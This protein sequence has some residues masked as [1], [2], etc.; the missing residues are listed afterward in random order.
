MLRLEFSDEV[1][2]DDLERIERTLD[3]RLPRS[4]L[5]KWLASGIYEVRTA[6]LRLIDGRG[7][8]HRVLCG[9]VVWHDSHRNR[10][11]RHLAVA[12]QMHRGRIGRA[13]LEFAEG[14]GRPLQVAVPETRVDVQLWL[15]FCGLKCMRQQRLTGDECDVYFFARDKEAAGVPMKGRGR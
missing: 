10:G 14:D 8:D 7:A 11:I 6:W 3:V 2:L 13:L 12:K 1:E 4:Q 15:R 5:A 9:Y